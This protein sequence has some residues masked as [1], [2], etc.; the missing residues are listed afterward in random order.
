MA[1]GPER[2][3][4]IT[5]VIRSTRPMIMAEL[6]G[7]VRY[8]GILFGVSF[9]VLFVDHVEELY[10]ADLKLR[11]KLGLVRSGS[12]VV[13]DNVSSEKGREYVAWVEEGSDGYEA[14]RVPCA[15]PNGREMSTK[16]ESAVG[17]LW[18]VSSRMLPCF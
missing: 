1:I 11:E 8:P 3:S 16:S 13:A 4:S 15:F 2:S 7:Y 12:V 14:W 17:C 5:D 9:D 10:L 6:G 18:L